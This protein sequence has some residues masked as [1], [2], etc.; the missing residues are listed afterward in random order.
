M[1]AIAVEILYKNVRGVWLKGHAVYRNSSTNLAIR[2]D[3][4]DEHTRTIAVV[5]SG[6]LDSNTVGAI[7]I[8]SICIFRHIIALTETTDENV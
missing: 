1:G 6:I 5:N 3:I 2:N 4:Y 8:P 7:G